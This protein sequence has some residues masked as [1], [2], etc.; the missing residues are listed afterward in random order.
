MEGN[1]IGDT[2]N[3]IIV[4]NYPKTLLSNNYTNFTKQ[5]INV[6]RFQKHHKT[7]LDPES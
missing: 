2:Y 3:I 1:E 4:T 6:Q 5:H 7:Q